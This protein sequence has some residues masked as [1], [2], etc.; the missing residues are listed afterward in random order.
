MIQLIDATNADRHVS[1]LRAFSA[2]RYDVFIKRLG[3]RI[4]CAEPGFETDQFDG[5]GAIYLVVTD[6]EGRVAGGARLLDTS[7]HSLLADVFPFLV[8]GVPPRDGRIF[9]VTRFVCQPQGASA[10]DS[11]TMSMELLWGLQQ[12]AIGRGL[13]HLVSVS[14]VGLQPILRR[15]GYCFRALGPVRVMD[16]ARVV[17]LQH[18]VDE[19]TLLRS[20]ARVGGP[21]VMLH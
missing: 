1:L 13:S 16:S 14:Y 8:E 12:F 17:A 18:D 21:C 7:R 4:P 19:A 3:W 20:R 11:R 6:A 2:L 9:E 10:E 15:A 5:P